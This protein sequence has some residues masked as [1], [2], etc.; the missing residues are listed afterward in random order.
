MPKSNKFILPVALF[1]LI[2][3]AGFTWK[4]VQDKQRIT[5]LTI[6]TGAKTGSYYPFAEAIAQVVAQQNPQIRLKVIETQGAQE[7]VKL[8]EA[9]KAQLA[10]W[11]S[12]APTTPSVRAVALLY[13]EVFHLIVT[14]QSGIGNVAD[15]K[16]KR[17]ALM[18]KGSGSYSSFWFLSN[19]YGLKPQ[20]FKSIAVSWPEA[21]QAFSKGEVDA[22]FRVLPA[23]SS[24][25]SELLQNTPGNLVPIKQAAA[26]KFKLP[27]LEASTIPEGSYKSEP[28]VPET[29]LPS[30]GVRSVLVASENVAPALIHEIT[31]ILYE[32]QHDLVAR[33]T[34]AASITPPG[35]EGLLSL[36]VHP[37]AQSYYDREKPDFL[38]AN[39]D[40]LGFLLSIGTLVA[41]WVWSLQSRLSEK[42]KSRADKYNLEIISLIDQVM[43]LDDLSLVRKVRKQLFTIF[44]DVVKDLD[45]DRI[46]PES[47]GSFSFTLETALTTVR[48]REKVLMGSLLKT[49]DVEENL[50]NQKLKTILIPDDQLLSKE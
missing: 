40:K 5:Y 9:N 20:D 47:F 29:D 27:Y 45:K 44:K 8:L 7:N 1:S 32:Y 15:L 4:L 28:T 35:T 16:G 50:N 18:T 30:V 42:Q 25:V 12:D 10:L 39:V 34:L 11:Q 31:R 36:S 14:E 41:S 46:S 2:L 33:N 24:V 13:Q 37:G 6:A 48:D 19:H 23:G 49:H 22:I 38:A 3:V 17:I 43:T 26:M 21:S